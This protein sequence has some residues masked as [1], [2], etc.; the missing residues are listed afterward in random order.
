MIPT[1]ITAWP[2]PAHILGRNAISG[3]AK[4]SF[5]YFQPLSAFFPRSFYHYFLTIP[6]KQKS[7]K[8]EAKN[9]LCRY[10]DDVRTF[11]VQNQYNFFAS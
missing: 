7:P 9:V 1:F 8:I 2:R 3:F 11:W 10:V 4:L 6:A 5:G